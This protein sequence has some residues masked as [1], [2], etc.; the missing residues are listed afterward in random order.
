MALTLSGTSGISGTLPA[1]LGATE[2]NAL[3]ISGDITISSSTN[4]PK[5]T[6]DENGA[7]DP[8][9]EIQMDQQTGSSGNLL[10]KVESGGNLFT[11]TTFH[12]NSALFCPGVFNATTGSGSNQVSVDSSG[13]LR[14]ITSSQRYKTNIET[15]E[16]KY[17]DAILEARPVWYKS[18]CEDDNK[19]HGH[20][21][22]I[23]EEIEKIDP[24]L[25]SYKTIE[26]VMEDDKTIEKKLD[27]PIVES[28]QYERFIPHLINLVKRQDAKIKLLET[29]VAA[30]EAN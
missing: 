14:R 28:V 20:W 5:I 9:A 21:G 30:L 15:L 24:R 7:D 18:L 16:D 2:T 26:I 19:N 4:A 6:F 27:T 22:F 25:C 10:V 3:E 11:H 8:K 1:V 13:K 29:K 17:A 23:A 12:N